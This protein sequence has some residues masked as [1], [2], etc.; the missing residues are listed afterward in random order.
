MAVVKTWVVFPVLE[1]QRHMGTD[2]A[3]FP[4]TRLAMAVSFRTPTASAWGAS[5]V[6]FLHAELQLAGQKDP[7]HLLRRSCLGAQRLFDAEVHLLPDLQ[8][9]TALGMC[10]LLVSAYRELCEHYGDA[11]SA[12]SAVEASFRKSYQAFIENVCKPL[13]LHSHHSP[14]ALSQM[15]FEVWSRS[16]PGLRPSAGGDASGYQHFFRTHNAPGLSCMVDSA[17]RVWATAMAAFIRAALPPHTQRRRTSDASFMRFRF[18]PRTGP[19]R[20]PSVADRVLELQTQGGR[21]M[22]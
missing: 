16:M 5:F 1:G 18:S 14:Q 11:R 15:N 17:D 3:D 9:C 21:A 2:T 4:V 12:Y 20:T 10:A 13:Y 6:Q 8:A 19:I 22:A 7:Q